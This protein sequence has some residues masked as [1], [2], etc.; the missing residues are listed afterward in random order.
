MR[1]GGVGGVGAEAGAGAEVEVGV[2]VVGVGGGARPGIRTPV[3]TSIV[4]GPEGRVRTARRERSE[5]T[6]ILS[7][8]SSTDVT[9]PLKEIGS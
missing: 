7:V 9:Q 1:A 2:G 4:G 5:G 6:K 8:C 3:T